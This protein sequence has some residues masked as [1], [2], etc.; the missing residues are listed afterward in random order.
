MTLVV[1]MLYTHG[2]IVSADTQITY[3]DGRT[4]DRTKIDAFRTNAF[5]TSEW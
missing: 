2:V 3:P 1:G 4:E 5:D